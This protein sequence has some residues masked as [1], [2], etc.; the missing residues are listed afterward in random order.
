MTR[1]K[2]RIDGHRAD[3]IQSAGVA[4]DGLPVVVAWF[5]RK[6]S[7]GQGQ[8]LLRGDAEALDR[9]RALSRACAHLP[10]QRPH[11]AAAGLRLVPKGFSQSLEFV[12]LFFERWFQGRSLKEHPPILDE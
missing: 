5:R 8:R 10:P 11:P 9:G 3:V 7:A 1:A 4:G 6:A 12:E 2:G